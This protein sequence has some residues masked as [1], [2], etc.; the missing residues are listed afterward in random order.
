[1]N[2]RKRKDEAAAAL[3]KG[4]FARAAA[5]YVALAKENPRDPQ[6]LVRLGE[7]Q[8]KRGKD[9]ESILA[10]L[11]AGRRF[12]ADGLLLRA[13]A[14]LK[15]VLEIAPGHEEAEA[16]LAELHARR[17]GRP[18]PP[19]TPA[20]GTPLP[21]P[22]G[23]PA[24][25]PGP[26]TPSQPVQ[27]VRFSQPPAPPDVE[28]LDEMLFQ[29]DIVDA[30]ELDRE[31][32]LPPAL[33]EIPLF[34]DLAPAAFRKLID[35]SRHQRLAP[36]E[37]AVRQGERGDAFYVVV[38]GSLE[39]VREMGAQ[40]VRLAV[41]EDGAFFGEMALLT[42]SARTASVVALRESEV[43]QFTSADLRQLVRDHT[44]VA[45]ALRRFYR[46][47]LLAN[48]L[49]TSPIFR[50]FDRATGAELIRQFRTREVAAGETVVEEGVPVEGLF[51]V[52]HGTFDVVRR[53]DGAEK[54]LAILREGELFG[55]QSLLHGGQASAS[56]RARSR[57]M[58]LRLPR[59]AFSALLDRHP[60]IRETLGRLDLERQRA[61]GI[62]G[63]G[64]L[65]V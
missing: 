10:F 50:P 7:V 16:L 28:R 64:S 15:L 26:Y 48:V 56:C 36:G 18:P 8:R 55:E 9:A 40:H 35:R 19:P 41:L 24:S 30:R 25:T 39:V 47:R 33:P 2:A 11:A 53:Q 14:A 6:L 34:A 31:A 21:K 38:D 59:E 45:T 61:G 1:M 62:R 54:P 49:A 60:S 29:I 32:T 46:Q 51:V 4:K 52:L 27:V 44:S 57:G 12:A 23:A 43:L 5:L 20:R 37:I 65:L 22:A 63:G 3:A 58:V 17:L 13:I 42:A